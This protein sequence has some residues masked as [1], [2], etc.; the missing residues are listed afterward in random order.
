MRWVALVSA[1]AVFAG[2]CGGSEKHASLE[3]KAFTVSVAPDVR[4]AA[5]ARGVDLRHLVAASADRAL[6]L[7]P[8]VGRIAITVRANPDVVI[9][10]IGVGGYV[11]RRGNVFVALDPHR[12]D[13]RHALRI[14]IPDTVAHEL[15]HSSRIR[16]GPGYGVTLGQAMVSE[17]LADRFSYE[18]F[19]HTPPHPW[20]H[21][22]TKAQERS[23]WRQAR[24]L[25]SE[26]DYGHSE[27]F[28]GTGAVPRWAGFTL[29]YELVGRYLTEHRQSPSDAVTTPASRVLASLR[30]RG[31][32]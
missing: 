27:W 17:G 32:P 15:H 6:V 26:R 2:G 11:D 25:L 30:S 12:A 28:F 18:V 10:E 22:L 3:G 13:L 16:M 14:W 31:S 23:A 20:D 4:A 21:A 9:P 1:L 29:G 19:P 7:L 8:H 5:H 24:P